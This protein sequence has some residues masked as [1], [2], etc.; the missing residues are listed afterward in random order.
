MLCFVNKI[1]TYGNLNLQN[2]KFYSEFELIVTKMMIIFYSDNR[3]ERIQYVCIRCVK[4]IMNN[5]HGMK[6]MLKHNEALTIV[7]RSLE[8]NK[9]AVM[10]EAVKLLGAVCLID[11]DSHKKVLAAITMNGEFKGRER[12]FPIVQGLMNKKNAN[13]RVIKTLIEQ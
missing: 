2:F 7:A 6:E 4:A 9:P 5:S 10:N 13:L 12:F 8:P 11:S 3:Y 1:S